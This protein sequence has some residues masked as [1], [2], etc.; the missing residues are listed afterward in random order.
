MRH[1][2]NLKAFNKLF[3]TNERLFFL[4]WTIAPGR[5]EKQFVH[6]FLGESVA[7]KF[8]SKSNELCFRRYLAKFLGP[9]QNIWTLPKIRNQKERPLKHKK[10]LIAVLLMKH[11]C[12]FVK[13]SDLD[14][15]TNMAEVMRFYIMLQEIWAVEYINFLVSKITKINWLGYHIL[16]LQGWS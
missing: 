2:L 13:L 5:I 15:K 10:L 4:S 8:V 9:S 16:I 6:C 7:H 1:F 3:I 11:I 12:V 14:T